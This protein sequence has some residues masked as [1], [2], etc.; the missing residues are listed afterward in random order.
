MSPHGGSSK[1]EV[2]HGAWFYDALVWVLTRGRDRQFRRRVLGH[3]ELSSG[4]SVLDVGCGTGTLAILARDAVGP[5]GE[6]HGMDPSPEMIA[7]ARRKA[8]RE[9]V[10]VEFE[11]A[12]VESLP[13]RD[14][15]FDAVLSTLM[16]HHLP[17]DVRSRGVA[18]VVRVLKPGGRLVA[19]DIGGAGAGAAHGSHAGFRGRPRWGFL[20]GRRHG[21]H[22]Y[23]FSDVERLLAAAGLEVAV[24][25]PMD[26]PRIFGLSDLR[27][28]VAVKP[29]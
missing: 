14:A 26:K 18:E 15:R 21:H 13:F 17:A 29:G 4:Q 2:L 22:D 28:V 7:R 20:H 25:G 16:L 3:A 1:G 23:S 11:N 10:R 27:Y 5:A 6:V 8:A 24:G 9:G 12:S 19:V